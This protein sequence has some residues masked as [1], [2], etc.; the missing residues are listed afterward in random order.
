MTVPAWPVLYADPPWHYSN[1]GFRQSAARHYRTMP[2]PEICGLRVWG[3]PVSDL[4][5]PNAVL[6]LWATAPML[7]E[8]H[9]VMRAWGF[10]Y[11]EGAVWVKDRAPGLGF[12]F[13]VMEKR[14]QSNPDRSATVGRLGVP[15]QGA[16][17]L[18]E[19]RAGV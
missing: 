14:R 19:A 17:A 3:R 5:T 4:A 10:E 11:R 8:G 2:T 13:R 1:S 9:K 6:F 16:P 7:E 18:R 12:W 15:G